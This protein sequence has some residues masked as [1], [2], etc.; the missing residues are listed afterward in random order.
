MA[1]GRDASARERPPIGG[2]RRGRPMVR[3]SSTE[4][5]QPQAVLPPNLAE[6][7]LQPS[8]VAQ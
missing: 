8:W 5:L 7:Y 4:E 2:V 6:I 1:P 3:Q